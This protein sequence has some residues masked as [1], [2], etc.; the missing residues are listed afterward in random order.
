MPVPHHGAPARRRKW[1]SVA[2]A[3]EYAGVSAKTIRRRILD[4]SLP[5]HRFGPQLI[6]I[7][8]ADLDQLFRPVPAGGGDAA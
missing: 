5:A 1:E 2:S 8:R 7:D 4:G 6:K 3:A